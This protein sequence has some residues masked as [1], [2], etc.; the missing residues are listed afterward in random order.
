M[1][2]LKY[3][4]IEAFWKEKVKIMK[5][6]YSIDFLK[7]VMAISIALYHYKVNTPISTYAVTFF[8]VISGVFLA[9]K[10][11]SKKIKI[12]VVMNILKTISKVY[13][14]IICYL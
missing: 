6:I 12:I 8:F 11:Y 10:Y 13:I 3:S 14:H 2:Q 9:K 4:I 5:R 7:L 1:L